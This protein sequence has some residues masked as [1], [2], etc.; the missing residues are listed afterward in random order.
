MPYA[1]DNSTHLEGIRSGLA[2][3]VLS[4]RVVWQLLDSKLAASDASLYDRFP[5]THKDACFENQ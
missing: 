3:V 1:A 2:C 5:L 4:R